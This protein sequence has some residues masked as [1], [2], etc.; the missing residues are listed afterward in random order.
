MSGFEWIVGTVPALVS[1]SLETN[2]DYTVSLIIA[3]RFDTF[4]HANDAGHA[5]LQRGFH[6]GDITSFY[7]NPAGQHSLYPLGGDRSMDRGTRKSPRGA[8]VGALIGLVIGAVVGAL[9]LLFFNVPEI[10]VIAMSLVFA[11]GG[12]LAGAMYAAKDASAARAIVR[13]PS[14]GDTPGPQRVVRP[15]NAHASGVMV[16]VRVTPGNRDLARKVLKTSGGMDIEQAEGTWRDGTWVDFDPLIVPRS[17][18]PG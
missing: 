13:G 9:L 7:V 5:L 6:P 16:A 1:H 11:Y 17:A 14:A 15:E 4:P 18:P 10:L 2:E 12:S 8:I 3:A